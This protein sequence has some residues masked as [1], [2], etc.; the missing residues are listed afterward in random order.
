MADVR[1]LNVSVKRNPA[2]FTDPLLFEI[3]F[4]STADLSS[5]LEFS[6]VYVG[7]PE[8]KEHDQELEEVEVG[9]IAKGVMKFELECPP[10]DVSRIPPYE[11]LDVTAVLVSCKYRK[12]E[13]ARVGYYVNNS[14]DE[15]HAEWNTTPPDTPQI[16]YIIRHIL[17]D[18]PRH[19][20]FKIAWSDCTQ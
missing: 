8:D 10:P 16:Q 12:Q 3:E 2:R 18:K 6:I 11:L 17:S 1:I 7:S 20:L 14:Y 13:F 19:T 15:E 5:D 4:E 9:P